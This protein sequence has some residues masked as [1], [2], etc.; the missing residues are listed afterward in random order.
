[1]IELNSDHW[2]IVKDSVTGDRN[3]DEQSFAS[4]AVLDERLE[5]IRQLGGGFS[6]I[7]LSSAVE[8][9]RR[10]PSRAAAV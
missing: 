2:Q 4:L 1:M 7:A 5:R 6:D 10:Q 3:I 9:L 8:K